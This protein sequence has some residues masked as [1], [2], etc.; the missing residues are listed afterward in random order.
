[1]PIRYKLLT[2]RNMSHGLT[3]WDYSI[4]HH[5]SGQGGLCGPGWLHCYTSPL[6]AVMLNPLHANFNNP[7]LYKVWVS[8]KHKSDMGLKEG[9]TMMRLHSRM[10][11]PRV[12]RRQRMAFAILCLLQLPSVRR[13]K[14]FVDWVHAWLNRDR[15]TSHLL[16]LWGTH[17]ALH[18]GTPFS[19]TQMC[20]RRILKHLQPHYFYQLSLSMAY[21][22]ADAVRIT[23][24]SGRSNLNLPHLARKA[25]KH[26]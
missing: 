19:R 1:M 7:R 10:K 17:A 13:N 6:L 23:R 24:M 25:M 12:S 8:G 9:W 14:P 18:S 4:T 15:N 5:T 2:Q 26:K 16:S 11:L 3:Y 21:D 22:V 20:M